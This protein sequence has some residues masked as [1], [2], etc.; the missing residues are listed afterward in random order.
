MRRD[1]NVLDD[2]VQPDEHHPPDGLAQ[3]QTVRGLV[4]NPRRR[5][6]PEEGTPEHSAPPRSVL[7]V[8]R[9]GAPPE[10]SG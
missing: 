7:Y 5:L 10:T 1:F 6:L 8:P 3:Q 9:E 4:G 2:V